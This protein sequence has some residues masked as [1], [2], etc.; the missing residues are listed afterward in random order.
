MYGSC[1][2]M[3]AEASCCSAADDPARTVSTQQ[4]S[5]AT[6]QGHNVVIWPNERPRSQAAQQHDDR[7]A[8]LGHGQGGSE[9]AELQ[10]TTTISPTLGDTKLMGLT[11]TSTSEGGFRRPVSDDGQAGDKLSRQ[12]SYPAAV[13]VREARPHGQSTP[14]GQQRRL[15]Q[16]EAESPNQRR[17]RDAAAER[18]S[19]ALDLAKAKGKANASPRK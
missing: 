1:S 8:Q 2:G 9:S 18:A 10:K 12:L 13:G 17:R 6:V 14:P 19:V 5:R 11:G 15:Q 3:G 7:G 4:D 16:P